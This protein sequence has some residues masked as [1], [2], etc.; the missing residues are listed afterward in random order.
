M[1]KTRQNQMRSF[2][3]GNK[4]DSCSSALVCSLRGS[5]LVCVFACTS[6]GEIDRV[7][8]SNI[9]V[10]KSSVSEYKSV[11]SSNVSPSRTGQSLIKAPAIKDSFI[12]VYIHPPPA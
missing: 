1:C 8:D 6:D 2:L 4:I 10:P 9:F 12:H 7:R 5:L 3:F 11:C